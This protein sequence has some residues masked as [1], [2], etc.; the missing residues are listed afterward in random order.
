[1][2]ASSLSNAAIIELLNAC[3]VPVLIDGAYL[4]HNEA[5]E[6][7]EKAA[8]RAVFQ[9]FHEANKQ[10]KAGAPTFSI[11]TVHA[12][13]LTA[14]GKAWD[15]LHVSDAAK[16]AQLLTMLE[17]ARDQLNVTAGKPLGKFAPQ[18]ACP[19]T[20]ADA[21]VLHLTARYL[22]RKGQA[23]AR[24]DLDDDLVPLQGAGLGKQGGW[25]SLPS[26]DWIVL[27]R[28]EWSKLL[29]AKEAAPGKSWD[30]DAEVAAKILVRFYPTTELNDLTKNRIDQQT[31]KATILSVAAGT[32]R[33]RLEGSLKMKHAFYPN[34]DDNNVV[35]ASFVGIMDFELAPPRLKSL[36]LATDQAVYGGKTYGPHP[37]GV[38]VRLVP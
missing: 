7:E 37:F 38:A 31:L 22:T 9:K 11:G 4:N 30:V 26:E 6:A 20:E 3:F 23:N 25:H 12:Y 34:R 14:D 2:R 36:W 24:K 19:R 21:L 5:S 32:A 17:K 29:P 8:Y 18:S 33:A 1:M 16:P 35:D 10:K 15:S 28:A 27:P 13:V